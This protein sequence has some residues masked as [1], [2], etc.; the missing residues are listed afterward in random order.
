[1]NIIVQ[2]GWQMQ[3]HGDPELRSSLWASLIRLQ[4]Q[5][6]KTGWIT[7]LPCVGIWSWPPRRSKCPTVTTSFC[8]PSQLVLL[9]KMSYLAANL[10]TFIFYAAF[11]VPFY[12]DQ[13]AVINMDPNMLQHAGNAAVMT[14]TVV[15]NCT[16]SFNVAT[17]AAVQVKA[18]M[19]NNSHYTHSAKWKAPH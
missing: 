13:F 9:H 2:I 5:H 12:Q 19:W 6:I 3:I 8:V 11:H 1:M 17:V 14:F 16:C 18:M 10:V 4:L 7:H 15:V